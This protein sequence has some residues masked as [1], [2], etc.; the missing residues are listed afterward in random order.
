MKRKALL[1]LLALI[2]VFS[3]PAFTPEAEAAE[4]PDKT[5]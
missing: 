1:S 2:A 3:L 4:Y 5:H